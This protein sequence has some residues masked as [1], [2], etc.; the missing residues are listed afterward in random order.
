[1]MYVLADIYDEVAPTIEDAGLDCECVGGG[2][3]LHDPGKKK[4]EIFGYS[5]VCDFVPLCQWFVIIS[6]YIRE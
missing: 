4:I 1:M 6:L 5:Q 3:I 2:R